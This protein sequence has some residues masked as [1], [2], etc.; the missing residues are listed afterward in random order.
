MTDKNANAVV[1]PESS[2]S[3]G[4]A[5]TYP[6]MPGRYLPGVPVA[7]EAI[8]LDADQ[9]SSRI[10]DLG[11]PLELVAHGRKKF[12]ELEHVPPRAE[13]STF[14]GAGTPEAPLEA[15]IPEPPAGDTPAETDGDA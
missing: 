9:A 5:V 7:L 3:H 2:S 11:L 10:K 6:G 1:L 13:S 15:E 4:E 8:E 14:E 12:D